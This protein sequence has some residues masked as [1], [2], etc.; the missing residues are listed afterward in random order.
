MTTSIKKL[1]VILAT[2]LLGVMSSGVRADVTNFNFNYTVSGYYTGTLNFVGTPNPDGTT[3]TL[4][5]GS[6]VLTGGL[7]NPGSIDL[8]IPGIDPDGPLPMSA[9]WSTPELNISNNNPSAN[10]PYRFQN[11]L[12]QPFYLATNNASLFMASGAQSDYGAITLTSTGIAP[13]MNASL[14]PQVGLLLGCLFF[15]FGRKKEVV[16][17]LLP[18]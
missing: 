2:L 14:I 15:L 7:F 12:T 8:V 5:S 10:N 9:W 17:P 18:A 16:E 1:L 4:I 6:G 3:Y 11:S 13:E